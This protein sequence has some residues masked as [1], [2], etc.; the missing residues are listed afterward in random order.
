MFTAFDP[1]PASESHHIL[2]LEFDRG[3]GQLGAGELGLKITVPDP[4]DAPAAAERLAG[5]EVTFFLP[6][7]GEEPDLILP[8]PRVEE[9]TLWF[10][11]EEDWLRPDAGEGEPRYR[12]CARA[13]TALDLS[14]SGV[15]LVFSRSDILPEEVRCAD[16]T[17]PPGRFYPFGSPLELYAECGIE[18]AAAL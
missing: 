15:S 10:T 13:Q 9:D 2:T 3:L 6:G 5:P 14:L 1:D 7:Q 12:L 8:R 18:C 4:Q 16:I 17:Q 11:L